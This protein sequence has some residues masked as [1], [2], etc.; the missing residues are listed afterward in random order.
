[1]AHAPQV[2][3]N[4]K[5]INFLDIV[6]IALAVSLS[7]IFFLIVILLMIVG[8]VLRRKSKQVSFL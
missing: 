2:T 4:M 1:M 7:S 5:T 8:I 6:T 3:F